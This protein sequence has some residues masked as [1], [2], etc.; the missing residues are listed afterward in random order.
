M[1][2]WS[3][4]MLVPLAIINHFKPTRA[5]KINL[6]ELY[7]EGIHQRDLALAPDPDA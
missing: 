6:N 7:P 2:S 1:S 4:S 3:R 5:L